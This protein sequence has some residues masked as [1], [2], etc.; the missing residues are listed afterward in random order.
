MK[1]WRF[2]QYLIAC[3]IAGISMVSTPALAITPDGFYAGAGAGIGRPLAVGDD[4]LGFVPMLSGGYAL[5]NGLRPEVELSYRPNNKSGTSE[6]AAGLMGNLWYDFWQ[7]DYYFYAGGGAGGVRLKVS[8]DGFSGSDTQAAW[9]AG[10]GF[11]HTVTRQLI[12]G[13]SYRHLATFDRPKYTISGQ[14]VEGAHYIT[15][16]AMIE[17]RY[18]FGGRASAPASSPDAPVRVVP[19]E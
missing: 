15:S 10:L 19:V 8:A 14:S 16:A 18:V 9:Q 13:V 17:L 3:A 7:D 4:K 2:E 12:L 1:P 6:R 5:A 11:G